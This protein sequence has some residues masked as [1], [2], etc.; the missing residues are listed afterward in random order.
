MLTYD[1]SLCAKNITKYCGEDFKEAMSASKNSRASLAEVERC[2]N[3]MI[4]DLTGKDSDVKKCT[5][6]DSEDCQCYSDAD[7]KITAFQADCFSSNNAGTYNKRMI[8]Y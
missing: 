3:Y 8:T 7:D 5:S 1:M 6:S 2:N 4:K